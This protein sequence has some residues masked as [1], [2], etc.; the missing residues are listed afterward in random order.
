MGAPRGMA[1]GGSGNEVEDFIHQATRA[2]VEGKEEKEME[3]GRK[4][5][6]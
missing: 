3:E 1:E 4:R 5:K 2:G 6:E